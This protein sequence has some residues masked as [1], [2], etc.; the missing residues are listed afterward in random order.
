[1]IQLKIRKKREES[2]RKF[3]DFQKL[4]ENQYSSSESRFNEEMNQM[5]QEI[6]KRYNIINNLK[7]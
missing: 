1:M 3:L 4:L 2:R 7:N 5:S 6:S